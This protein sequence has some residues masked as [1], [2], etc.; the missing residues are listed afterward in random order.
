[1]TGND[2]TP[3]RVQRDQ[4]SLRA[5]LVVVTIVALSVG[6]VSTMRRLHGVQAELEK[7]RLETGHLQP[8]T[9]DQIAAVRIPSE[10]PLTYQLR[11]RVPNSPKFRIA[12]SSIWEQSVQHPHWFAAI[13]VPS[14]ESVVTV[15]VMEDPR[16]DRWKITTLVRSRRGTKRM[17]TTLPPDH[18]TIFRGSHDAISMGVKREPVTSPANQ[19]LRLLDERWLTGEGGLLLYGNK[20]PDS[21]QIGIYAELQQ[22]IGGL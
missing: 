16:D 3:R 8:T 21:D 6:L 2:Q 1:M 15:R 14:G 9:D 13:D 12:Y 5:M 11:I 20:P 4:F 18:V 19:S 22:D 17:A 7:L 10:Q